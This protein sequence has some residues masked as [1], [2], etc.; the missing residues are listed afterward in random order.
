MARPMRMKNPGLQ[1]IRHLD[2]VEPRSFVNRVPSIITIISSSFLKT[3]R[4][5]WNFCIPI[6]SY[7]RL[8]PV[9]IV[10]PYVL[11]EETRKL[12]VV[13]KGLVCQSLRKQRAALP[14][15]VL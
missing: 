8:S 14:F 6:A 10:N 15:R 13:K 9:S 5:V 3:R 11:I 4:K 1:P 2:L 12:G 7:P